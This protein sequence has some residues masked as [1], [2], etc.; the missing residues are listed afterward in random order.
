MFAVRNSENSEFIISK[1]Q[2]DFSM[3]GTN[4]LGFLRPNFAGTWFELYDYGL[5]QRYLNDLPKGFLPRQRHVQT[6][7]YDSNFFAE[8]PRSFRITLY[9]LS[10]KNI[11]LDTISQK[12]ENLPPKYNE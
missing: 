9:D 1:K 8:K 7:E 2:N 5:E 6:I 11:G 3:Y 10:P 12:F 4:F